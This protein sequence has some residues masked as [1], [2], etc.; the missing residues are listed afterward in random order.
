[1]L[2]SA[3]A[4][5]KAALSLA[6]IRELRGLVELL[7]KITG[8]L[9]D[10]PQVQIVNV[11]TSPEWLQVR[12]ALMGALRPYPDAARAVAGSLAQLEVES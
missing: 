2:A 9:D 5:G 7:A 12:G 6:A 10:R 11:T 3:E 8:E 4:E 1:V